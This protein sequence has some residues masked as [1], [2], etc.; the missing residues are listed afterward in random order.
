MALIRLPCLMG[1]ECGFQTVE[2]EYDKAKLQLD[3]HMQYAHG[4]V[5]EYTPVS[6]ALVRQLRQQLTSLEDT[7]TAIEAKESRKMA[8]KSVQA[9]GASLA[10]EVSDVITMSTPPVTCSYCGKSCASASASG[11]FCPAS[12][13]VCSNCKEIGHFRAVC[14]NKRRRNKETVMEEAD[15]E[16]GAS[17]DP[18]SL[19][20]LSGGCSGHS[21]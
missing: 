3:G 6:P 9:I 8:T 17:P 14:W 2:L 12:R 13:K 11:P 19:G 10:S 7:V 4:A 16:D 20:E 15:N 21:A 5:E 18:I 1:D